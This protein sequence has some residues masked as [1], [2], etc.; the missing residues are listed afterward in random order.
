MDLS[1]IFYKS[2]NVCKDLKVKRSL[3]FLKKSEMF[4]FAH[5]N[6]LDKRLSQNYVEIVMSACLKYHFLQ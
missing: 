1:T 6:E 4:A 5:T 2:L 3:K